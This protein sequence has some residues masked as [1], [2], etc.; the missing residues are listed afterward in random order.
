[1][2]LPASEPFAP[3]FGF[4]N[5]PDG[6]WALRAWLDG[7]A[8]DL[9]EVNVDAGRIEYITLDADD[10]FVLAH[11]LMITIAGELVNDDFLEIDL[12]QGQK[13]TPITTICVPVRGGV[14]RLPHLPIGTYPVRLQLAQRACWLSLS[15]QRYV[16]AAEREAPTLD[17]SQS[18]KPSKKKRKPK[19]R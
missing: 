6:K 19:L 8:I 13:N 3:S 11:D 4:E 5:I 17:L 16:E 10:C 14:A 18:T 15:A 1:M 9:G 12:G 7:C 2:E